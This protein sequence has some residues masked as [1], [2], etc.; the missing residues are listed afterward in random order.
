MLESMAATGAKSKD[1]IPHLLRLL[2]DES[3]LLL[4][5]QPD[6]LLTAF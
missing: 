1:I 4:R 2:L 3:I 6:S 5:L